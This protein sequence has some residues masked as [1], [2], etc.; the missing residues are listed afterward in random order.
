MEGDKI[1]S[2]ILKEGKTNIRQL[3]ASPEWLI[4]NN[5]LITAKA[6]EVTEADLTESGTDKLTG[7]TTPGDGST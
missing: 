7:D 1:V 3:I 2:D 5:K 4:A 6:G